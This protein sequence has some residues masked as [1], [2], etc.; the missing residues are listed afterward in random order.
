MKIG[1][2]KKQTLAL[3]GSKVLFFLYDLCG[4]VGSSTLR[5]FDGTNCLP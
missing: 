2:N 1:R 5:D 4:N 3:D